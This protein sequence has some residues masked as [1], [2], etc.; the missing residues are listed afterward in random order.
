MIKT[1]ESLL[2]TPAYV[3]PVAPLE[4]E[5]K[6]DQPPITADQLRQEYDRLYSQFRDRELGRTMLYGAH[7]FED[8]AIATR[9][10][11]QRDVEEVWQLSQDYSQYSKNGVSSVMSV[12]I[13]DDKGQ[14]ARL[15]VKDDELQLDIRQD[16]NGQAS[17]RRAAQQEVQD[18][19]FEI[20][21]R[22]SDARSIQLQRSP[23]E[24]ARAD[25]D[26]KNKLGSKYPDLAARSAPIE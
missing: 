14:S 16:R 7:I 2:T 9:F 6:I 20:M 17:W 23:A 21:H 11:D 8:S 3:E 15:L 24:R 25:Q 18:M 13:F 1:N 12:K 19:A 4:L 26:A 5:T 10:F 22:A